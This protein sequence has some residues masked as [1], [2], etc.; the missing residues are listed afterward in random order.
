MSGWEAAD[1]Y[2]PEGQKPEVGKLSWGRHAW[3]DQWRREH[4]AAREN[5]ILMDMSFMSKFLVQGP[6]SGACL[7]SLSTANV[8][9]ENDTITY[10]QWLDDC[11]KLQLI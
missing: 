1:W 7:N 6:D 4:L 2:A 8:N 10:T 5:V 11:G 3:F 9:S